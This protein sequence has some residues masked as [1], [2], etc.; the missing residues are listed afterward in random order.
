MLKVLIGR[1]LWACITA[2]TNEESMPP[3]RNAPTGT[4]ATI[5]KPT[6]AFKSRVRYWTASRRLPEKGRSMPALAADQSDQYGCGGGVWRAS[7][8]LAESVRMQPGD[9]LEML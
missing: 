9:N 4:S 5:C 6:A 3:E 2:T 7:S 8:W 1:R